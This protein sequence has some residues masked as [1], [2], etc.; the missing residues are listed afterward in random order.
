MRPLLLM[1]LAA[2]AAAWA[3]PSSCF[4]VVTCSR[5][6]RHA[7]CSR[8]TMSAGSA[9]HKQNLVWLLSLW[10]GVIVAFSKK[11]VEH[12]ML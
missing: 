1:V 5:G 9:Q 2:A 3:L 10:E 11:H 6:M 12:R 4:R 8:Q 7:G